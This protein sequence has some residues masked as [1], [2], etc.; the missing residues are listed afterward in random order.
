MTEFRFWN[1]VERAAAGEA[2]ASPLPGFYDGPA[3]AYRHIVGAAE[4]RRRFGWAIAYGI[5]T[6]NEV[7]GTHAKGHAPELRRMDDHNNAIGLSIG[8]DATSNEE[9]VRRAR[10]AIDAGVENSGSGLGQTPLWLPQERWRE[11]SA[12]PP[13]ERALPV[14]WPDA[15]PS[16]AAYRFGD[17]RFG[18]DRA[19]RAGTPRER[20]AALFERLEATPTA[21]WSEADV[22]GVIA[23][24]AYRNSS[25]AEHALWRERVRQYFQ[26]RAAGQD[27]AAEEEDADGVAHVRAYT[28]MGPSGPIQVRAHDRATPAP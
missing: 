14:E 13:A 11:V 4:L 25:A 28:R 27:Q 23:S 26:E 9:V 10:A 17:E 19:F 1:S 3:D 7:R 12:R 22:R 16:A 8:A 21:E 24:P 18:A 6:G 5:V 15:I 20:Q 2:E